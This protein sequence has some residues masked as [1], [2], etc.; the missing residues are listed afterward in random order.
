ML[1]LFAHR[2]IQFSYISLQ[3][4]KLYLYSMNSVILFVWI[5]IFT[6]GTRYIPVWKASFSPKYSHLWASP[7]E[8]SQTSFS[9]FFQCREFAPYWSCNVSRPTGKKM[10]L[11][12]WAMCIFLV[13]T[14]FMVHLNKQFKLALIQKLILGR[15]LSAYS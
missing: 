4:D 2:Q 10:S 8:R 13:L 9:L 7:F 11:L 15:W 1:S 5:S 6:G 3:W 14:H 12:S